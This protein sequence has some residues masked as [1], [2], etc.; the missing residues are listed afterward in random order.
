MT[1]QH[2]AE[3]P[4]VSNKA[5]IQ[6]A[7]SLKA[8]ELLNS[9][10]AMT[11]EVELAIVAELYGRDRVLPEL[12]GEVRVSLA[13]A[14]EANPRRRIIPIPLLGLAGRRAI[15]QSSGHAEL[16]TPS[17]A[18][19]IYGRL[20]DSPDGIVEKDGR[21][22]GLGYKTPDDQV[23]VGQAAYIEAMQ[24]AGHAVRASDGT[25][26]LFPLVDVRVTALPT[27]TPI[28]ELYK[29]VGFA[30]VP[31]VALAMQALHQAA[32]FERR[33][34]VTFTNEAVYELDANRRPVALVGVAG[35]DG[36]E[37]GITNLDFWPAHQI[38][39][40]NSFDFVV[41]RA[42]SESVFPAKA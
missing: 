8:V 21:H 23:V 27:H 35:V 4:G 26:W 2:I 37:A 16:S 38:D 29:R 19:R 3:V 15:A 39:E 42:A 28:E 18:S 31:E 33:T 9:E 40:G 10:V 32:G 12:P 11:A 20:L 36:I 14:A 6:E 41:R 30:E 34:V 25:S 1:A 22:Y 17:A 7:F 5:G 13:T 24:T